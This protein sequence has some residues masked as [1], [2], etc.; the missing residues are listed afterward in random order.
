MDTREP[1]IVI[2]GQTASGK[3]SLAIKLA[4]ILDGE[5]ICADSRTIYKGMDLGTAKPAKEE[6]AGIPHHMLDVVE[7]SERYTVV[8]FQREA[9]RLISDITNRGKVPIMVGGT[10]LYI[11]AVI[12]D[13]KFTPQNSTARNPINPR[14]LLT[15]SS[16]QRD[17]TLRPNT[18]VLGIQ[19]E[20]EVLQKRIAERVD[21]MISQGFIEEVR[22]LGQKYG[23][24]VSAMQAP[25]YRAFREYIEGS[26]SLEEAK[27][28]FV[29]NDL[30]LA[31]RQRTW[32]RRNKSIQWTNS[33]DEAVDFATTLM[34]EKQ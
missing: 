4:Q 17:T 28:I 5:I 30:S 24:Q 6:Q 10:G 11:D 2:V 15:D 1:L 23:W 34:S 21:H 8:D 13:Y 7:P 29:K 32:F 18:L 26:I 12:F 14:H 19:L 16:S 31:K 27:A 25:G 22:E 9:N 3:T 33:V 20:R